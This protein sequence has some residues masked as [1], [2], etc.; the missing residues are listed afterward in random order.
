[1]TCLKTRRYCCCCA[2]FQREFLLTI[3]GRRTSEVPISFP[4]L[5]TG[6]G[7]A[8]HCSNQSDPDPMTYFNLLSVVDGSRPMV[9]H[10]RRPS[11][12]LKHRQGGIHEPTR[13]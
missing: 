11:G 2:R 8:R 6:A 7:P 9:H 10:V 5:S 3:I 12:V 4:C 13:T 1:M